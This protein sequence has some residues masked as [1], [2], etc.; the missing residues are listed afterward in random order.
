LDPRPAERTRSTI[1]ELA[2]LEDA[3][4]KHRY[5]DALDQGRV[6]RVVSQ[7]TPAGAEGARQVRARACRRRQAFVDLTINLQAKCGG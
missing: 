6:S 2:S 1:S 5:L 4:R 3:I 7:A